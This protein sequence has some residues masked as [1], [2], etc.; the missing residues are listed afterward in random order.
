MLFSVEDIRNENKKNCVFYIQ[1]LYEIY[2]SVFRFQAIL[3]LVTFLDV[4]FN[5]IN[6]LLN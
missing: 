1:F 5:I 4:D 3:F 2:Q 6:N